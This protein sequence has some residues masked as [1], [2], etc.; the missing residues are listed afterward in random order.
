MVTFIT[1]DYNFCAPYL[2][3]NVDSM[4]QGRVPSAAERVLSAKHAS[5]ILGRRRASGAVDHRSSH[6]AGP[7]C[8]Q[9]EGI[10]TCVLLLVT[11]ASHDALGTPPSGVHAGCWSA[12]L[13][14]FCYCCVHV[15]CVCVVWI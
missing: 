1:L 10:P 13:V 5:G 8:T 11:H 9:L 2:L 12:G 4:N 15:C 6:D 3:N 7:L 14:S